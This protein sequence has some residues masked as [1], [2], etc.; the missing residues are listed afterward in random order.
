MLQPQ[1]QTDRRTGAGS[2]EEKILPKKNCSYSQS[3]EKRRIFTTLKKESVDVHSDLFHQNVN[4][5][6]LYLLKA[7][8]RILGNQFRRKITESKTC[9]Q[10][11]GT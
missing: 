5:I 2:S 6:F 10:H 9:D 3:T 4:D 11:Q 1:G 8:S 7:C